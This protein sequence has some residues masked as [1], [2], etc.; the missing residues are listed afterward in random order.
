MTT[1]STPDTRTALSSIAAAL[2]RLYFARFGFAFV[3]ALLLALTASTLGPLSITLL[4]LYPVVDLAAAVIDHRASRTTKPAPALFVNMA[5]SLLAAIG[6]GVAVSSGV[7][8]VLVVWGAWAITAGIV[9]LLVAVTRRALGGQWPMI[10]SGG[11]SVLAGA[12][13]I[14]AS[15]TPGASLTNLAGYAALGGLFFLISALRLSR[16]AQGRK[17]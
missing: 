4:L 16:T 3:W 17:G 10:L 9:Q 6:L 13:F 14:V 11:I 12:S 5:L 15:R 1:T 7:S 8:T 2:R